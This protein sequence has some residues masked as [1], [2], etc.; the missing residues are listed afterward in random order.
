MKNVL[1]II[2]VLLVCRVAAPT[3]ASE[4]DLLA[5]LSPDFELLNADGSTVT[6]GLSNNVRH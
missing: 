3:A 4:E 1:L 5:G 6:I 2:G